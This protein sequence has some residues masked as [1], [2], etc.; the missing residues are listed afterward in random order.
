M[1][2]FGMHVVGVHH[3]AIQVRDLERAYAF[4][5]DVLGMTEMRR[6]PHSIWLKADGVI[7]MLEKCLGTGERRPFS[8]PH[9][10]LHV[11]S[12]T[13]DVKERAAWRERLVRACVEI[14]KESSFTLYVRD[15]DGTRIGLS[16]FPE[17]AAQPA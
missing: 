5:A 11:L 12:L 6:Q 7:I 8:A 2:T 14:E 10:G 3:V 4:Y 15:P 16:H 1:E 13:I 9:E 17:P